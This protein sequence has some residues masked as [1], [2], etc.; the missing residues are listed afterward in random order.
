MKK[1][2][3]ISIVIALMFIVSGCLGGDNGEEEEKPEYDAVLKLTF[4]NMADDDSTHKIR[5]SLVDL[6]RDASDK[7]SCSQDEDYTALQ[8]TGS[9]EWVEV[10]VF[11]GEYEL[12]F[13][14]YTVDTV[15]VTQ[16]NLTEADPERSVVLFIYTMYM[17]STQS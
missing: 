4:N 7:D 2:G 12:N 5:L 6:T 16:V 8:Y 14:D 11:T 1:T 10:E 17:V 9:Q 13:Y 3:S 15:H